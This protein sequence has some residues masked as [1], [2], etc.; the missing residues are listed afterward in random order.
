MKGNQLSLTCSTESFQQFSSLPFPPPLLLPGDEKLHQ[1]RHDQSY[2]DGGSQPGQRILDLTSADLQP[3][4][5]AGREAG[6][7]IPGLLLLRVRYGEHGD[8]PVQAPSNDRPGGG[9]DVGRLGGESVVGDHGGV[10]SPEE[11]DGGPPAV[12]IPNVLF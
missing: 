10:V 5:L 3:L 1:P 4:P 9:D 12:I 6:H 2:T 8:G 7:Q 11:S